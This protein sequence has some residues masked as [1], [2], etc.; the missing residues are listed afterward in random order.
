MNEIVAK[1][2]MLKGQPQPEAPKI[3][4]PR[5]EGWAMFLRSEY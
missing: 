2:A 4:K 1:A 3:G 5:Y